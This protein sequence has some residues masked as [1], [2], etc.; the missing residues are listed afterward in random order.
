MMEEKFGYSIFMSERVEELIREGVLDEIFKLVQ[1]DIDRD[2][3]RT[4]ATDTVSREACYH[5][6]HALNRIQI[7]IASIV[8]GLKFDRRGDK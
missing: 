7:K 3:K 6:S 2:W 5:E 8:D 4:L 1:E